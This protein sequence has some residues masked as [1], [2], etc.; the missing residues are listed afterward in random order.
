MVNH[1]K[2][3]LATSDLRHRMV[4]IEI[5]KY[6]GGKCQ[7]CGYSKCLAAL[8]LH[9][10][11]PEEKE[12]MISDLARK[13]LDVAFAEADKCDLLC[14]CCHREQHNDTT[15]AEA[16]EWKASRDEWSNERTKV[17]L[18]ECEMCKKSFRPDKKT[19]KYC[20]KECRVDARRKIIWPSNLQELV[21][22]SSKL[23]VAKQLGVS[24]KAVAKRLATLNGSNDAMVLA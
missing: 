14:A 20:S 23:A 19:S 7:L 15:V 22:N 21:N 16:I 12:F 13:S 17:V 9:H 18:A 10:R 3:S 1:N 2:F 5:V 4:K 11:N 8:E 6:K 24:D